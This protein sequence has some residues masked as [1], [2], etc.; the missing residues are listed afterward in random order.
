M[1]LNPIAGGSHFSSPLKN[2]MHFNP[3]MKFQFFSSQCFLFSFFDWSPPP[4]PPP[5][6]SAPPPSYIHPH[7]TNI[8][9]CS[10]Y[11]WRSMYFASSTNYSSFDHFQMEGNRVNR[12]AAPLFFLSL[13][14]SLSI[15]YVY[16][17]FNF[18][19]II[20]MI[21]YKYFGWLHPTAFLLVVEFSSV[22]RHAGA[23]KKE[24][25][26]KMEG[27]VCVCVCVCV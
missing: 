4:L 15:L 9:N 12:P 14:L 11:M 20:I 24:M 21:I 18:I 19:I 16:F 13:S 27:C 8:G 17:F 3:R 10:P 26:M 22:N 1:K 23:K 2:E 6:P 5:P 25:K 7:L